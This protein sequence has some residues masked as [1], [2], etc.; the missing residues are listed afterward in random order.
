MWVSDPSQIQHTY[1]HNPIEENGR[2]NMHS[3]GNENDGH[4]DDLTENWIIYEKENRKQNDSRWWGTLIKTYDSNNKVYIGMNDPNE[5][6]EKRRTN[7]K[8][9]Q[10]Q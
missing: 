3:K 1:E 5:K 6:H 9:R 2:G 8:Q 4:A 7:N 10:Q